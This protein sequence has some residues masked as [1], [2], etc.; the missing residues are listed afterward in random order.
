MN[1][2][3]I[4]IDTSRRRFLRTATTVI[5]GIGA[6]YAAAPFVT[7]W[8]PSAKT[9]A[10][11][12]PLNIDVSKLEPGAQLTVEWRGQPIWVVHRTKEMLEKLNQVVNLLR[13][14][15]SEQDQQPKYAQNSYRSIKPDFLVLI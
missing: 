12:A 2:D 1:N 9:Q 3:E 14:P 8:L 6:L 11:G 10:M 7:S 15:K 4:T 5:G 13:D